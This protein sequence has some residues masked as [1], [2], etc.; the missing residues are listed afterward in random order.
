MQ[1]WR[2]GLLCTRRTTLKR[3]VEQENWNEAQAADDIYCKPFLI[4]RNLFDYCGLGNNS[5]SNLALHSPSTMP[6]MR[7]GR[8]RRWK[9]IMAFCVSVTS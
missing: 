2:Q 3:V 4:H 5:E 6:S 9:A 1:L 7:S 8:K